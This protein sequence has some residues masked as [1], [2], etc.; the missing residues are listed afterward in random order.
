MK[1]TNEEARYG[2]SDYEVRY[3]GNHNLSI[4]NG[5]PTPVQTFSLID[6]ELYLRV[7]TNSDGQKEV[8]FGTGE[9]TPDI[10]EIPLEPRAE[11]MT[12]RIT[13]NGS[14]IGL[15]DLRD[16]LR[17][18]HYDLNQTT[19]SICSDGFVL[20]VTCQGNHEDTTLAYYHSESGN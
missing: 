16:V 12:F 9:K 4:F 11:Q 18:H 14:G 2:L 3:G 10:F 6:T 19:I 7:D 8:V 5:S 17:S 15:G 20:T 1:I 13:E